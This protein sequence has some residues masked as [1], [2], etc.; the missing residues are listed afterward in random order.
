MPGNQVSC[1]RTEKQFP[2]GNNKNQRRKQACLHGS[3]TLSIMTYFFSREI[4]RQQPKKRT[5]HSV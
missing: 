5:D 2:A 1:L 4:T 3:V